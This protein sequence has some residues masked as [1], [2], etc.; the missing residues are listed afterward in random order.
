MISLGALNCAEKQVIHQPNKQKPIFLAQTLEI[1]TQRAITIQEDQNG[2]IL[3]TE[4]RLILT[5]FGEL[6]AISGLLVQIGGLINLGSEEGPSAELL[7][8]F[9]LEI[10]APRRLIRHW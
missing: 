5:V 10:I 6:E 3:R 7:F 2:W 1:P 4:T 8:C 9:L